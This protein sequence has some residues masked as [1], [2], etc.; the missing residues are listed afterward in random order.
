MATV[1]RLRRSVLVLGL[2]LV[3]VLPLGPVLPA[4]AADPSPAP[5]A[6]A[7]ATTTDGSTAAMCQSASDL[8]LYVG[9]LRSSIRDRNG[10]VP[11]VVGAFAAFTEAR[12]LA[13]L[14]GDTYKPLVDDLTTSIGDLRTSVQ[15]LR[16]QGT[17]GAGLVGVGKAVV[18]IGNAMDNL[19]TTLREPCGGALSASPAPAASA[20]PMPSAS[21]AA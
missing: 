7:P 1:Q 14:V 17:L 5:V 16:D 4:A 19:S 6:S 2:S 3:A 11:I 20:I 15:G 9:F 21:P 8:A 12:N 10:V 18:D 13:G